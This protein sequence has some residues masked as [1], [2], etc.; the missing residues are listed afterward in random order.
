[1]ITNVYEEE[2]D[3]SPETPHGYA[4][5]HPVKNKE[6]RT[7]RNGHLIHKQRI[8]RIRSAHTHLFPEGGSEQVWEEFLVRGRGRRVV[9]LQ[10]LRHN[11]EHI[12]HE[13]CSGGCDVIS[14]YGMGGDNMKRQYGIKSA[15][16]GENVKCHY[17]KVCK[18]WR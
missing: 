15:S 8:A 11:L 12:W 6:T 7:D 13:F 10:Q 16:G 18:W 2:F 17:G 4:T 9:Q 1:M 5:F 14:H 3:M